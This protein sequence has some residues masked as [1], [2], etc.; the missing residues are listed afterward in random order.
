MIPLISSTACSEQK[1]LSAAKRHHDSGIALRLARYKTDAQA[2]S[3]KNDAG[4]GAGPTA[5]WHS[6]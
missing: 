2:G 3:H 4:V 5:T 1:H 6:Q